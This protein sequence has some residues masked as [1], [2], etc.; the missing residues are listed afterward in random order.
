MAAKRTYSKLRRRLEEDLQSSQSSIAELRGEARALE[1]D[2]TVEGGVP[3]NHMAD[4]GTSVYDRE[5]LISFGLEMQDRVASI[6]EA[7]QRMDDGA[8]GNCLRCG[9]AIPMERLEVLPFT[10]YCVDCQQLIDDG[11]VDTSVVEQQPAQQ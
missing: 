9:R 1:D 8:F 6:E 7:L 10:S 5:R 3:T 4:V 2:E 11:M